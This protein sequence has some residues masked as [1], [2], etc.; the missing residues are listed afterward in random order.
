MT[1]YHMGAC[2]SYSMKNPELHQGN[3][4]QELLEADGGREKNRKRWA[5]DFDAEPEAFIRALKERDKGGGLKPPEVS[6]QNL[7][8]S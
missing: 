8:E 3:V 4:S 2:E 6:E 5:K 7:D 1:G